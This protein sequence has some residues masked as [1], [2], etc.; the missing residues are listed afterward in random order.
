[1]K[2]ALEFVDGLMIHP[3]VGSTKGD[4]IPADVR[5]DCYQVML[6][7]YLPGDRAVLSVFPAAMRYAGPREAVFSA[8][9]RKN[10]GCSH[11]IVG[12]DH[13]G[14]GDYYPPDASQRLFTE[15]RDFPI[16]PIFY[17]EV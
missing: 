6:D 9:C 12:R 3:L 15:I 17:G 5:M 13:T 11:F 8:L 4:D 16:Q 10:F 14:V 1:M 7:K 2:V